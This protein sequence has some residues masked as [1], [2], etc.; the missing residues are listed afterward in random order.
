MVGSLYCPPNTG[1]NS[2]LK[3]YGKLN[4]EIKS[5]KYSDCVV[6]MD[7]NL[8]LLKHHLDASTQS[9][10]ELMLDYNILPCVTRPMHITPSTAT[11][12]D[13]LLVSMNIYTKQ[14]TNVILY[15]MS[16]HLLCILIVKNYFKTA[17]DKLYTCKCALND[18]NIKKL[19]DCLGQIAWADHLSDKDAENSMNT[20]HKIIMD[21]LDA[22]ALEQLVPVSTNCVIKECW[23]TPGL[24]KCL[25]CLAVLTL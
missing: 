16:D 11:L 2:F 25:I 17:K 7:H 21:N 1:E 8:D 10:L 12:I 5:N 3:Y 14:R 13:N 20:I 15:E 19:S 24:L 23:M 18:K 9:F 22:V 4:Q 6:G